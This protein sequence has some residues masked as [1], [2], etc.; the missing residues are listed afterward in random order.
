MTKL[1]ITELA[2]KLDTDAR[3]TRK[4]LRTITPADAQPGKGSRWEIEARSVQSLKSKFKKFSADA[5]IAAA[6]RAEVVLDPLF[7]TDDSTSDFA[8]AMK[9]AN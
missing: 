5:E 2:A 1:N 7:A 8:E 6:K 9:I 3:T 4:F